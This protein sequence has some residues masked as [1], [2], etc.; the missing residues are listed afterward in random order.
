MS[1]PLE[2]SPSLDSKRR[3]IVLYGGQSP[4]HEVSRVTAAHVLAAVDREKYD[5]EAV[6]ID[7]DG[8]W[9]RVPALPSPSDEPTA[10]EV[11]GATGSPSAILESDTTVVLPL[12]HGP[13]GEDERYAL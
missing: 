11:S 6:G 7:R 13:M 4:E 8:R 3:V 5:V 12:I 1:S 2:P 10:L 9:H